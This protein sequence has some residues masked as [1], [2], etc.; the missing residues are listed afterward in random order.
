MF[1]SGK[2][3]Y[4]FFDANL[5]K[6]AVITSFMGTQNRVLWVHIQD[7]TSDGLPIIGHG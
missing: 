6:F 2:R 3:A 5:N 7:R 4:Q 1:P